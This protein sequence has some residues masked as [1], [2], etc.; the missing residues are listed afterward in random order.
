MMTPWGNSNEAKQ[1]E[2]GCWWVSCPGHGGIMVGTAYAEKHL[3]R[4]ARKLGAPFGRWLCYEEDCAWAV[5]I[6]ELPRLAAAFSPHTPPAELREIAHRTL[7]SYFPTYLIATGVQ[8]D[9]E[10]YAR[11]QAYQEDARMR[12]E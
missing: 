7:S 8:P 2:V 1:L 12:R 10:M 11:W 6:W 4:A 5:V 9:P 3:T